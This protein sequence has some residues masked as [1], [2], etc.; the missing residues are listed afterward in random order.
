[1]ALL[2]FNRA[3]FPSNPGPLGDGMGEGTKMICPRHEHISRIRR[4]N[5]F[6]SPFSQDMSLRER[7]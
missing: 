6:S 4:K 2:D 1:M 3:V 7:M 5:H